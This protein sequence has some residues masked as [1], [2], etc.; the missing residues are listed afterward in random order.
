MN[1]PHPQIRHTHEFLSP[2][3][4]SDGDG[5]PFAR[6]VD[7]LHHVPGV[8]GGAPIR[9]G[10]DAGISTLRCARARVAPHRYLPSPPPR[11]ASTHRLHALTPC[12][13]TMHRRRS[14]PH[15]LVVSS[16]HRGHQLIAAWP[17]RVRRPLCGLLHLRVCHRALPPLDRRPPQRQ[18]D[19][20]PRRFAFGAPPEAWGVASLVGRGQHPAVRRVTRDISSALGAGS[21]AL[22]LVG[23]HR[24]WAWSEAE[25]EGSVWLGELPC[26]AWRRM[27]TGG[28]RE[29]AVVVEVVTIWWR[30]GHRMVNMVEGLGHRFDRFER[31]GH[32]AR[33]GRWRRE[34]RSGEIARRFLDPSTLPLPT[35]PGR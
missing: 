33:K 25:V 35:W 19:G 30:C 9:Y 16:A 6:H 15:G 29:R 31:A 24:G 32:T 11:T 20:G 14:S 8:A 12:T 4:S 34:G 28:E 23:G 10:L 22:R 21:R 1:L 7:Q 3:G 27:Q 17:A 5:A 13:A 26:R 18:F 2:S